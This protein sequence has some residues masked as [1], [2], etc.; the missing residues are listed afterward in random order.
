[1]HLHL[2]ISYKTCISFWSFVNISRRN[3]ISLNSVLSPFVSPAVETL[4]NTHSL[5]TPNITEEQVLKV[6]KNLKNGNTAGLGSIPANLIA[7]CA[8]VLVLSSPVSKKKIETVTNYSSNYTLL[9]ESLVLVIK[10]F[11]PLISELHLE[12]RRD[13]FVKPYSLLFTL[14]TWYAP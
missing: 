1:M 2:R 3:H 12:Y 5:S 4:A 8:S 13:P 7:D 11:H 9:E 10:V 14:L 6:S